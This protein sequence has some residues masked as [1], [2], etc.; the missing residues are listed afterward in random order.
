MRRP[1]S[2]RHREPRSGGAG[3]WVKK[4]CFPPFFARQGR[5]AHWW[6]RRPCLSMGELSQEEQPGV[7]EGRRRGDLRWLEVRF[8]RSRERSKDEQ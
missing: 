3:D 6:D 4:V 8:F 2:A 1:Y 7:C 5:L